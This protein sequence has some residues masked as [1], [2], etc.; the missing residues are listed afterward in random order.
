[1]KSC[2]SVHESMFVCVNIIAKTAIGSGRSSC[3]YSRTSWKMNSRKFVCRI[4][5]SHTPIRPE[6]AP[7]AEC[8]S[9]P[10]QTPC[11]TDG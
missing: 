10:V 3:P 11:N 4:V 9:P 2:A 7:L 1:M 5:H 8:G 6:N